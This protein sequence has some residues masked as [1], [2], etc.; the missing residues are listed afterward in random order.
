M[1]ARFENGSMVLKFKVSHTDTEFKNT[2]FLKKKFKE[3]IANQKF[4]PRNTKYSGVT[5]DRKDGIIEHLC[6]KMRA[7][8]RGFWLG[9]KSH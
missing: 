3:S 8:R 9:L 7:N 2:D 1:V 5:R 6:T 4:M